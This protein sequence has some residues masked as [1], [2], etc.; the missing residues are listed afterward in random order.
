MGCAKAVA[1]STA[2]L[3]TAAKVCSAATLTAGGVG[4]HQGRGRPG[5]CG[6]RRQGRR[7]GHDTACD[8]GQGAS[9]VLHG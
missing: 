8:G 5:R 1:A 7:V 6:R 4:R 9:P 3:I 2:G